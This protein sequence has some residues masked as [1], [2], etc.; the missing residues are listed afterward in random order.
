[1]TSGGLDPTFPLVTVVIP[2][3]NRPDLLIRAIQSVVRQSYNRWEIVVVDDGSTDPV[4]LASDPVGIRLIRNQQPAG[5]AH[6]RNQG[7]AEST[8]ELIAFLDDDDVFLPR[9]LE[10]AV[11]CMRANPTAGALYHPVV[12]PH[13]RRRKSSGACS[14]EVD[15][16]RRMLIRQPPHPSG[17]VVRAEV[18][19]RVRFDQDFKAA[20]DLDY[21]LRL[22]IDGP[23]LKLDQ[24]LGVHGESRLSPSQIGIDQ[25]IR[26]REQFRE[27]H[28]ALFK[29]PQ[30]LA[31]HHTRISHLY[32]RSGQRRSALYRA[33]T[34]IRTSP[35]FGGAYI[36]LLASVLPSWVFDS[37]VRLRG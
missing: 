3:H 5:P 35:T 11:E 29:D 17:L 14:P 22:A 30:I 7:V 24:V 26:S 34:A 31:F 2:S 10:L 25:R 13:A 23:I 9:K 15:R 12:F 4:S 36:A 18:H 8:G 1:M 21:C 16:I 33:L 27:K 19:K 6:A 28:R 20:A 37:L 32:R